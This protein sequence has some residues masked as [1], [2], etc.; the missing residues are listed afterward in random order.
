MP[1]HVADKVK[2]EMA[3]HYGRVMIR[4]PKYKVVGRM[5]KRKADGRYHV[6]IKG[7]DWVIGGYETNSHGVT[8]FNTAYTHDEYEFM[9]RGN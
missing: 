9:N 7:A 1:I 4:M 5:V 2:T 3:E 8:I 6:R